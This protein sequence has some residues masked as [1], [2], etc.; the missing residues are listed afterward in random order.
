MQKQPLFIML[1]CFIAG[2]LLAENFHF[3]A[4]VWNF[5]LIASVLIGFLSFIPNYIFQKF[6]GV[7]LG[8]LFLSIGGFFHFQ[9]SKLPK[10]DEFVG[11]QKFIFKITK[12][13]NSNERYRRYE[14]EI[15]KLKSFK[16]GNP[17]P[18][19]IVVSIPKDE[20]KP[21]FKHYYQAESF[22][23]LVEHPNN[24][25][26]FDYAKFLSRKGICH[27]AFLN[28]GIEPISRK[29]LSF[30]EKIKQKR[31]EILENI[32]ASQLSPKSRELLKGIIL[33][34]RTEM[35]SETVNDFNR[36][37][38]VHI[39]AISG[40]HMAIIFWTMLFVI[41]KI[42]PFRLR[43]IQIG[44]ALVFIWAFAVLIDY[45]P[46]VVRSCIMLTAYY[47]FVLLQRK[48]DLLNAVALAAFAILL[49]DT[50]QLYNV[51]FQLSF[52]A[53]LGIFWMNRPI[54]AWFGNLANRWK[55]LFATVF[56]VSLSAQIATLPLVIYYFHQYSLVSIPA[57][58]LVI[59]VVEVIIIFSLFLATL[60]SLNIELQWLTEVY[61]AAVQFLL[62]VIHAFANA[63]FGFA[64]N[65]PMTLA[66]VLLAF[67]T[68]YFLRQ[69]FLRKK[70]RPVLNFAAILLLFIA[71]RLSLNY[72]YFK[73]SEV[74]LVENFQQKHL[75][76]KDKNLAEFYLSPKADKAK[77]AKYLVEP[78]LSKNRISEFR[79]HPIPEKARSANHGGK[80][81]PLD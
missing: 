2:I 18:L 19:K 55:R 80:A 59:P 26:Q 64:K 54:L 78:Y 24:D 40:T 9:N 75:I 8:I 51:G 22:I 27:Q 38:L 42:L 11:R 81:Y 70:I 36:S 71:L 3:G 33:A 53:V 34:D 79:I 13:L 25:F 74:L 29:D 77:A 46:S 41:R 35:D 63:D 39:L 60:F 30:A 14:A 28:S 10:I 69:V 15:L 66:E 44:L 31:L 5:I 23:N 56:S 76:I 1:A 73:K 7:F 48:P 68:I 50:H 16:S 12:K 61:D 45:G 47:A 67:L 21:D 17:E 37:G 32:D 49:V 72:Y 52:I 4:K 62:K 57:N 65:I 43:K 6:R 20:V 58:L